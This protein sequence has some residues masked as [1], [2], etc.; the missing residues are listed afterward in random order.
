MQSVFL[1]AET[2]AGD[3]AHSGGV[4]EAEAVE[5]V[6]GAAFFFGCYDGLCREVDGGE[7]VHGALGRV[8]KKNR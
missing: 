1:L 6:W 8:R 5:F 7:E 3:D 4:Q 2:S